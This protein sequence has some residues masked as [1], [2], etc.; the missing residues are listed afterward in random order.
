MTIRTAFFA[1]D[2][3]IASRITNHLRHG[4]RNS[5]CVSTMLVI[6][7][8]KLERMLLDSLATSI[9]SGNRQDDFILGDGYSHKFKQQVSQENGGLLKSN[10]NP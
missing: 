1:T 7:R 4:D 10:S 9:V 6:A 5:R 3:G 2:S 8:I